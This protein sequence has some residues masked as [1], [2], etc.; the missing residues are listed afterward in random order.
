MDSKSTRSTYEKW[1][2]E[3]WASINNPLDE[4]LAKLEISGTK[5][6]A[7]KLD[8]NNNPCVMWMYYDDEENTIALVL[9]DGMAKSGQM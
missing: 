4:P 2:G 1:D 6:S 3:K 8:S 5:R 7:V 9:S